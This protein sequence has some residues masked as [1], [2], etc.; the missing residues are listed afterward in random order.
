[1]GLPEPPELGATA[2]P[3]G[4]F[5]GEVVVVTGGGTGLGKAMALEFGRLGAGVAILSRMRST[6]PPASPPSKGSEPGRSRPRRTSVSPIRSPQPSTTS[7][8]SSECRA[9]S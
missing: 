1:M 2:L 8:R 7:R 4:T 5:E 3:P 6:S 9:S